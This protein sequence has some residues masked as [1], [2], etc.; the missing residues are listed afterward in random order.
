MDTVCM[1]IIYRKICISDIT[2]WGVNF[3]K[4]FIYVS[5]NVLCGD[6]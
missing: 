4:L 3:F 5:E 6:R 1:Q 2:E